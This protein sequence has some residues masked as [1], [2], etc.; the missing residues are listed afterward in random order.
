MMRLE[1]VTA[2]FSDLS[3]TELR[4]WVERGW[5]TP[6]AEGTE[7]EFHEIDVARVRLVHMLRHDIEI[8]EDSLSLVLSLL[9]QLYD[10]RAALRRV[11]AAIERQPP[12]TR[13][14]IAAALSQH[15]D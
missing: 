14:L 15:P 7:W 12:E 3:E 11:L 1:A 13:A 8:G 9:D 5:I 6:D 2:L 4:T 10:T